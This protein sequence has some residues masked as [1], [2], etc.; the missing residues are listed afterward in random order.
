MRECLAQ[1]LGVSPSDV[2]AVQINTTTVLPV[3]TGNYISGP[4]SVDSPVP[5]SAF[6]GE[7]WIVLHEFYHVFNQWETGEMNL[8]SY[9]W[10]F[11][12]HGGRDNPYELAASGFADKYSEGFESC[13]KGP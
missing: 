11:V 3:L 6:W 8:V 1:V 12:F 4:G 9:A 5:E 10:A 13:L 7:S 2:A